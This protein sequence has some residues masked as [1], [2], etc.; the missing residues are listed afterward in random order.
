MHIVSKTDYLLYRECQKNAWLKIHKPDVYYSNELSDFEKSIIETGNEVEAEA[1]L[2]FPTGILIEGRDVVAQ[3]KT[4]KL[5][6]DLAKETAPVQTLFQPVF[7]KD[8]FM[9]AVDVLQ[10]E[11]ATKSYSI[12]EI[13]ASN[14][15]KEKLHLYDLAFQVNLLK[16][17]GLTIG[18][19]CLLHLN[20]KYIRKGDLEI[21]RLFVPDD[22]STQ[23]NE[24]LDEVAVEM[25]KASEYLSPTKE[26]GGPC[27]CIYKGR[28]SHCTTFN[29]SNP[30]VP[31]YGVHDIARIGLSKAKLIEL[32]DGNIFHIDKIPEEIE[33]SEIQKN[34]VDAFITSR[35]K[36][37]RDKI[38]TELS[39]LQFPLYFIDYETFPS[40]IPRFD[41]FSPYQQIPFQYSLHIVE[42][43]TDLAKTGYEPVHREFLH[44]GS[45]D[46]SG[47]FLESMHKDI[48]KIGSIIVWNKKFE[49]KIND[50]LARRVSEFS[51][52]GNVSD[53]AN[54][55]NFIDDVNTRV[56]DLMD[57]FSKQYYV[58]KDFQGS[59]S[60]KYVLPVIASMGSGASANGGTSAEGGADKLSY[61]KLDIREGGTAS[62]KWNEMT[63]GLRVDDESGEKI[64]LSKAE[65]SKIAGDLLKY[66]ALDTYAMY[67]IWK[68]LWEL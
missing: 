52:A 30:E 28:S 23:V 32:I 46:P 42:S 21:T 45:D 33:L 67:A 26:P 41:G 53:S 64:A 48:G 49:C 16:M 61:K 40:A 18:K 6:A 1:R 66:C 47:P 65:Q 50:E 14:Q 43:A 57:I 68:H 31:E 36:I 4:A 62:M 8:G 44:V 39:A 34:Q 60:I 20:P 51:D 54:V 25:Q 19:I 12:Y 5:V 58:H 9:A 35:T 2:L 56:Y 11:A 27:E 3:E 63:T 17:C 55:R 22:V 24:R 7:V 13:K 59:T 10:Y 29:Y 37:E 38:A 15:V